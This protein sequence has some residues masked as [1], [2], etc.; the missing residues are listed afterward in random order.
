ME[1]KKATQNTYKCMNI[2][3]TCIIAFPSLFYYECVNYYFKL[4]CTQIN[5]KI[6]VFAQ[7]IGK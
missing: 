2:N 3:N 5:S 7:W 1:T 6:N 4:L